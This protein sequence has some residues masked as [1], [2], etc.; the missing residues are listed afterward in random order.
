MREA[1]SGDKPVKKSIAPFTAEHGVTPGW[2][3]YEER[4]TIPSFNGAAEIGK[5][6]L[7]FTLW[8]RIEFFIYE[9]VGIQP[10]TSAKDEKKHLSVLLESE[11]YLISL[12]CLLNN[13]H[14]S[15]GGLVDAMVGTDASADQRGNARKRILNRTLP[16]VG[17]RYGLID[18]SERHMGNSMEYSICR[19]ERLVHFAETHLL[20]SFKGI[21][22]GLEESLQK[23]ENPNRARQ[24]KTSPKKVDQKKVDQKK[25]DQK[26]V[27]KKKA[28][29]KNASPEKPDNSKAKNRSG[30][31]TADL[32]A[33]KQPATQATGGESK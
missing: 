27:E 3:V 4:P 8:S 33:I 19:S 10:L 23:G 1:V 21:F 17:D 31:K 18:Y 32:A 29:Q 30:Q 16:I 12:L 28:R 6:A 25:V 14:Y 5:L 2:G 7:M 26:E 20:T 24:K 9:E 13:D 15:A 22:G 11:T